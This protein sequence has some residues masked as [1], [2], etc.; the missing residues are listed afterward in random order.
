MSQKKDSFIKRLNMYFISGVIIF[1]PLTLTIYLFIWLVTFADGLLGK[2]L[3]PYF[4][5]EFGFYFRGISILIG[6]YLIILIGFFATHYLGRKI[7]LRVENLIVKLPFF[8]QVYPS[9]KEIAVFVFSRDKMAFRQVVLIQYPR[10]GIY[11]LGFLTNEESG[12]MARFIKGTAVCN[13]LIPTVPNPL[14]GF[15][16]IVPKTEVVFTDISVEEAVKY[17]VS[18]GVLNPSLNNGEAQ[19]HD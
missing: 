3:K 2:F 10:P 7:Y 15:V 18:G 16:V 1:L 13:V 8:R 9:I 12:R 4:I 17:I 6:V 19:G 5:R 14:S 11:S